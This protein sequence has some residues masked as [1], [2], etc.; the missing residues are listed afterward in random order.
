MLHLPEMSIASFTRPLLKFDNTMKNLHRMKV[1]V[2]D[3][4][5]KEYM[6]IMLVTIY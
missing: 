6:L 5:E 2:N 1:T 3:T 4:I